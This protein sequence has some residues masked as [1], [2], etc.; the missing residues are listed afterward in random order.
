MR[1]KALLCLTTMALLAGCSTSNQLNGAGQQVRLVNDKPGAQCQLLGEITGSQ[2]NWLSSGETSSSIDGATNDLR[3]KAA[4]MGGNVIYGTVGAS[5]SFWSGFV[6]L[7]TKV[8]GQ[9]YRCPN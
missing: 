7:D 6:P 5:D 4:A 3:N 8:I 2:G 9:V 1:I